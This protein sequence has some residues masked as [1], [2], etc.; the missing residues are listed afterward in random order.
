MRSAAASCTEG[1]R[2]SVE[3][4]ADFMHL[5]STQRNETKREKRE[6]EKGKNGN[7]ERFR[8]SS[9]GNDR[10]EFAGRSRYLNGAR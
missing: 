4:L 5:E 8:R 9:Q 1:W 3:L 7:G 6:G 10:E 2:P